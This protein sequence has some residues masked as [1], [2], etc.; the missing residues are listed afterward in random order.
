MLLTYF[1]IK[2]E[3]RA[4]GKDVRPFSVFINWGGLGFLSI[5]VHFLKVGHR[6]DG[7]QIKYGLIGV[8]LAKC[9]VI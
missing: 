9:L 5:L 4:G 7:T 6:N 3:A 8:H 2:M 1:N